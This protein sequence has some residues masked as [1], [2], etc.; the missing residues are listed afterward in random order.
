MIPA[1]AHSPAGAVLELRGTGA[2]M[3]LYEGVQFQVL[4]LFFVHSSGPDIWP[5]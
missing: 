3:A 1:Y 4:C 5:Y 2:T